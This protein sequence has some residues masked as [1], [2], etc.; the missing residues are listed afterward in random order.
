MTMRSSHKLRENRFG[1]PRDK[2]VITLQLDLLWLWVDSGVQRTR[3]RL[4]R[5]TARK[6][7]ASR[8]TGGFF[9]FLLTVI[10]YW[11]AKTTT[12]LSRRC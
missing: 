2:M 1:A 3:R 11:L 12:S 4:D 7:R 9:H 5:T 8:G 6:G 10:A